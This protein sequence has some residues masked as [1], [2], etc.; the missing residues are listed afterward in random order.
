MTDIT[1]YSDYF[2]NLN[3]AK[4]LGRPAPHKAILLLSVIELIECGR[5]Q[6][7]RIELTEVLESTFLKLWKRYVGNSLVFQAKVATPFW[8]LQ[9]EP[10]F[11][12]QYYLLIWNVFQC[13]AEQA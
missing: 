4:K 8:H 3:T 11:A 12:K 1:T 13:H 5:I 2:I 10:E 7:N 6:S 9:H